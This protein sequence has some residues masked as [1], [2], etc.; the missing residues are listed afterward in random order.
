VGNAAKLRSCRSLTRC[1]D[2]RSDDDLFC[3]RE[4][5]EAVQAGE[6]ALGWMVY[7]ACSRSWRI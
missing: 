3:S 1:L 4:P 2:L 6:S 7:P 5:R